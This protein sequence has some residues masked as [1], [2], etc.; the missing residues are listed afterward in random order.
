MLDP[1]THVEGARER[2]S[3]ES[4]LA[5]GEKGLA[6]GWCSIGLAPRVAR[7]G[8]VGNPGAQFSDQRRSTVKVGRGLE[9]VNDADLAAGGRTRSRGRGLPTHIRAQRDGDL[10]TQVVWSRELFA[11]EVR[12]QPRFEV[13]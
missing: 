7:G 2:A 6:P 4:E 10:P 11:D 8:Q 3:G 1:A 9:R 13:E 5:I 12:A